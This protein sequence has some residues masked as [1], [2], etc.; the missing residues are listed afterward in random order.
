MAEAEAAEARDTRVIDSISK[1]LIND[2][3]QSQTGPTTAS[4]VTLEDVLALKPKRN[5]VTPEEFEKVKD[6]IAHSFNVTQLKGVL[7]SQNRPSGGKKSVLI[8]QVMLF[9]DLEIIAPTPK[10]ISI[11]E[12]PYFSGEANHQSRIFPSN[13]RELFFILESEGDAVRQLEKEKHVRIS[14][15]IADETYT[16]RGELDAIEEAKGRIQELVAVTEEAWDI[17][18]YKDRE[19]VVNT[20]SALEE[21]ARRSQT[22]VSAGNPDTLT[23]AGRSNKDMEE[24]K[25]L[26]D[27]KMQK[28]DQDVENL[29]FT[30]QEDEFKRLGMFPVFDSATMTLD[31]NQKS[32]LR[33]CQIEPVSVLLWS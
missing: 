31:E 20:P 1:N 9:M 25:R 16:I 8:N 2:L 24:A 18:M 32:F 14:I 27:L 13:K 3:Y 28:P 26:F 22:F 11:V 30:H 21:I 10:N 19:A 5:N 12:D 33:V 6:A 17:S 7:R 15:N 23:I 29:T 4:R